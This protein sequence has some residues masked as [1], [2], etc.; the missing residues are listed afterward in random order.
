MNRDELWVRGYSLT[1][2]RALWVP[3]T[4]AYM[5]LSLPVSEHVLFPTSTGLAAGTSFRHAVLNALCEVIER[6]S[7]ALF[8]FPRLVLR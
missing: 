2:R 7:L 4:A 8:W 1:Q 6:D 5:G 3:L